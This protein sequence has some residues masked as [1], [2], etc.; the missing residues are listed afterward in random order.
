MTPSYGEPPSIAGTAKTIC[1][2]DMNSLDTGP[3]TV[4][5]NPAEAFYGHVN[6]SSA[7]PWCHK[8]VNFRS[9]PML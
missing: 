4:I 3:S 8:H 5:H 1:L 7:S 2:S 6:A 9:I